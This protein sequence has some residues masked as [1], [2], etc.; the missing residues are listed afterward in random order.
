MLKEE[1]TKASANLSTQDHESVN[2]AEEEE[3][4]KNNLLYIRTYILSTITSI[5]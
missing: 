1:E 2:S 3:Q 4:G 5:P